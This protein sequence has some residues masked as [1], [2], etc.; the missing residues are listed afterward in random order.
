[1]KKAKEK[2]QERCPY[3]G[4]KWYVLRGTPFLWEAPFLALPQPPP[5]GAFPYVIWKPRLLFSLSIKHQPFALRLPLA[6]LF[7]YFLKFVLL[8]AVFPQERK[9]GTGKPRG[10][11]HH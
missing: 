9:V 1:M 7:C 10:A 6:F 8:N 3:A 5:Q 4:S 2:S 11:P